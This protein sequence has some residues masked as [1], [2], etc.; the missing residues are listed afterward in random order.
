MISAQTL[1]NTNAEITCASC[2]SPVQ[3]H[4]EELQLDMR[5]SPTQETTPLKKIRLEFQRFGVIG[6][7]TGVLSD[8]QQAGVFEDVPT[9]YE[10]G[11]IDGVD[12][13]LAVENSSESR[14]TEETYRGEYIVGETE[15][16]KLKAEDAAL[17][18]AKRSGPEFTESGRSGGARLDAETSDER[19][20][21]GPLLDGHRLGR[22]EFKWNRDEGRG[23]NSRQEEPK[24]TSTTFALTG[25]SAHN[26]AVVYWSGQNSSVSKTY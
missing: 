2:P 6:K 23:G 22:S 1:L 21:P 13:K 11:S 17:P 16:G 8:G 5:A 24:L 15:M 26:H 7:N 4:L 9:F 18:R 10:D 12:A 19:R 14:Q 20:N 3:L 25:D